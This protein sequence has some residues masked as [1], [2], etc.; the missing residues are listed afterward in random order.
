MLEMLLTYLVGLLGG[1]A[2]GTQ[3]PIVGLMSQ[4][5]GATASSLIVHLGGT[6]LS[7]LLLLLRGGE[8][9]HAWRSLPWYMLASGS[10]GLLLYLSV[11]HTVPRIGAAG[12]ITLV[13]VG[14][15][16]AGVTLDHFGLF[17]LVPRSLEAGRAGGLALVMLGGYLLVR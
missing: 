11:A 1:M 15:L 14:Q 17:G 6:L 12:A 16:I 13:I 9:I 4:R 3:T 5:V 10:V 7:G 8:Q 2:V